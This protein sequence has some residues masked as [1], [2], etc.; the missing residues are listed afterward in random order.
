MFEWLKDLLKGKK[1]NVVVTEQLQEPEERIS[2]L[3]DGDAM[4]IAEN[5]NEIDCLRCQLDFLR[6]DIART[7]R[8]IETPDVLKE[9][10]YMAEERMELLFEYFDVSV[11]KLVYGSNFMDNV[12]LSYREVQH[13][14]D[15]ICCKD[16]T[17]GQPTKMFVFLQKERTVTDNCL[18]YVIVSDTNLSVA[19]ARLSHKI[20]LE[21]FEVRIFEENVPFMY[22]PEWKETIFA[23]W[24]SN[25][26]HNDGF[27]MEAEETPQ[28]DEDLKVWVA[29]PPLP[30]NRLPLTPIY[31]LAKNQNAAYDAVN[32]FIKNQIQQNNEFK[33]WTHGIILDFVTQ[34]VVADFED[35]F[36][37]Y[38]G[39]GGI[40]AFPSE[41]R[42]KSPSKEAFDK[43]VTEAMNQANGEVL[44]DC[45]SCLD[46]NGEVPKD[47]LFEDPFLA[48]EEKKEVDQTADIILQAFIAPL[49]PQAV[50]EKFI[51]DTSE[52]DETPNPVSEPHAEEDLTEKVTGKKEK[53]AANENKI[54][55]W[56]L[57][58]SLVGW[59]T[60]DI[61]ICQSAKTLDDAIKA[62]K[63]R[64]S[65]ITNLFLKKVETY[66]QDSVRNL[67][68]HTLDVLIDSDPI[69]I[70]NENEMFVTID[71]DMCGETS[72]YIKST[73]GD[74][75][76]DI[77][78][79]SLN[80]K[81]TELFS[82]KKVI[83]N[84]KTEEDA[85]K[86]VRALLATTEYFQDTTTGQV[87]DV[88]LDAMISSMHYNDQ[89][90]L[91]EMDASEFCNK[92]LST[93][94]F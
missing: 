32:D 54:Y 86:N 14:S 93:I 91:S 42:P 2:P 20:N 78:F 71:Q 57:E 88:L 37:S 77:W 69:S 18:H 6:C 70:I 7:M 16:C 80:V 38:Y 60:D 61:H 51:Y 47:V 74:K 89:D 29:T 12:V 24:P 48:E 79:Y 92:K 65:Q 22:K 56:N 17:F 25:E 75:N 5:Y 64:K 28:N 85:L 53:K 76:S 23:S 21:D 63:T 10:L 36:K 94:V 9:K 84:A 55:I 45:E 27:S 58:T 19:I 43:F 11:T 33:M 83:V 26:I 40:P 73:K 72:T 34:I 52:T 30:L 67:I 59:T 4:A 90:Q 82:G 1:K 35:E 62:L 39:K 44:K 49:V 81:R 50:A 46:E 68:D 66:E 15:A 13:A 87:D 41:K 31:V 3:S 8:V